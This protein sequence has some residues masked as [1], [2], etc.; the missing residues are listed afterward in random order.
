MGQNHRTLILGICGFLLLS[1]LQFILLPAM[2]YNKA[3]QLQVVK[4]NKAARQLEVL[5]KEYSQLI[6]KR[7]KLSKGL[8]KKK[9]TLFAIIEKVA[10]DVDVNSNID[11]VRP[12]QHDLENNLVEEE[13]ALKLKGLYQKHLVTFLYKIEKELQGIDVK[14][15]NIK[16]TKENLLDVDITLTMVTSTK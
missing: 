2:D 1:I 9:G 3:M 14:N 16:H 15:L 6:Q 13:V 10:R 7:K 12:Q 5:T 8:D 4:N 11:A